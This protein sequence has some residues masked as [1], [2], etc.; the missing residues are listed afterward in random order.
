MNCRT[1][2]NTVV[3]SI[4]AVVVMQ[5]FIFVPVVH[6]AHVAHVQRSI[7]ASAVAWRAV[8]TPLNTA[9]SNQPLVLLWANSQGAA[10]QI[11]DIVN[12]GS[13]DLTGLTFHV[14]VV[15][16]SGGGNKPLNVTFEACEGASWTSLNTCPGLIQTIGTTSTSL[17]TT[18]NQLIP[19]GGRL[20]VQASTPPAGTSQH[21]T[22][23][24]ISVGTTHLR[25]GTT[26]SS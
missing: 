15:R 3:G 22:T 18:V 13:V 7:S 11:F 26:T 5:W 14:T 2:F 9:P 20:S 25:A 12:T 10:Y 8:A 4:T 1:R 6:A 17:T 23:I 16:T 24:D 19:V 21:S